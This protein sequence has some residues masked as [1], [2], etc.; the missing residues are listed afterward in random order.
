MFVLV[1]AAGITVGY[2]VGGRLRGLA[3]LRLRAVWLVWLPVAL[4]LLPA[5]P[6]TR[7]LQGLDRS[8]ALQA[9]A[10][11][12]AFLL[13]NALRQRG[14]IRIALVL[15]SV[16]WLLNWAVVVVNGGMP[17]PRDFLS[18]PAPAAGLYEVAGTHLVP[19][20]PISPTTALPWLGD[21]LRL[22]TPD[23]IVPFSIGDVLLVVGTILLIA[24]V[25][26]AGSTKRS[27]A[28]Y[29][30]HIAAV[31]G[32]PDSEGPRVILGQRSPHLH[33]QVLSTRTGSGRDG[34]SPRP[35]PGRSVLSIMSRRR[36]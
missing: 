31:S 14:S 5:L 25:M 12:G 17:V 18:G 21:V 35:P 23:V 19:H 33:A 4:S 1:V 10:A 7:D 22:R 32:Q 11:I 20:V 3:S 16:G 34:G 36:R 24:L 28:S 27:A 30:P 9:T 13:V 29:E 15:M 26:R 2:L 8:M 6:W